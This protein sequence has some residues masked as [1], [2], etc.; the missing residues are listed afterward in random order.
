MPQEVEQAVRG[1]HTIIPAAPKGGEKRW[2]LFGRSADG[3][4]LVVVFTIRTDRFRTVTAY[5]MNRAER[6]IYATQIEG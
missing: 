2:K 1:C 6:R 5:T 3:R 4:Y